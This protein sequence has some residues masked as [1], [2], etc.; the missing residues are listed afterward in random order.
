MLNKTNS[1]EDAE[2]YAVKGL[3]RWYFKNNG[4]TANVEERVV[5]FLARSLDH[6]LDLAEAEAAR[7]CAEDETAN[8]R[9]EPLGWWNAYR[10]GQDCMASNVEV[11][12]RLIETRLSGDSFIKR[13]FPKSH[14][15]G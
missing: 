4:E 13:Y 6:A 2:W 5:L 8:F 3:F 15:R 7:Y 10:I 14:D 11:Y 1:N 12:S 9:I